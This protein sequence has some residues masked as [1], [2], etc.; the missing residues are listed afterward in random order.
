MFRGKRE[1]LEML[2]VGALVRTADGTGGVVI[3]L[4]YALLSGELRTVMIRFDDDSEKVGT[5]EVWYD[6][7]DDSDAEELSA[8]LII[9][10]EGY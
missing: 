6:L 8:M 4:G 9:K 2:E 7:N 1:G 5:F 10:R 3:E